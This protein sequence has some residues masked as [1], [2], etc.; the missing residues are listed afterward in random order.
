M[1]GSDNMTDT[2]I[3]DM[4]IHYEG[5]YGSFDYDP[6]EIEPIIDEDKAL[7]YDDESGATKE[8]WDYD[9]VDTIN[10][11]HRDPTHY[12]FLITG[13]DFCGMI[14]DGYR[15]LTKDMDVELEC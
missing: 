9:P 7:A 11:A 5:Q 6:S 3:S 12:D 8:L 10:H 4:L 2:T 1:K 15:E 14:P 13:W